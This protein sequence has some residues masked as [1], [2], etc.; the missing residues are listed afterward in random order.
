MNDSKKEKIIRDLYSENTSLVL[1]T[2]ETLKEE[3]DCS[4][5]PALI[6]LMMT[7][8][9]EEIKQVIGQFLADIK[10]AGAAPLFISAIQNERY[11]PI[12]AHLIGL[13][14][15]S[16]L[17]FTP[18]LPV[19]IEMVIVGN[20][21]ESFEAMTVIE[22]LDGQITKEL[23][24]QMTDLLN[25]SATNAKEEKAGYIHEIKELLPQL[26]GS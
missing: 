5:I 6:D 16:G 3:G 18:F 17:D 22:N 23:A 11:L 15:Q 4:I 26:I 21:M 13:C 24:E 20:Y 14:W 1:A 9:H 7:S 10:E 12:R 8:E 2:I 25:K 19:F